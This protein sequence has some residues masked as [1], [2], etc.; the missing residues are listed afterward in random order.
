MRSIIWTNLPIFFVNYKFLIINYNFNMKSFFYI[1]LFY[2]ISFKN[3]F[4][5]KA[6]YHQD[7]SCRFKQSLKIKL[8]TKQINGFFIDTIK[9]KGE[10]YVISTEQRATKFHSIFFHIIRVNE[11]VSVFEKND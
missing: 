7:I 4:L 1:P 8:S 2:F 6:L 3:K 5:R 9:I 11:L 10:K